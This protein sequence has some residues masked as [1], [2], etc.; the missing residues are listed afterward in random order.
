MMRNRPARYFGRQWSAERRAERAKPQPLRVA[1]TAPTVEF[2][3]PDI[4]VHVKNRSKNSPHR[5]R[6]WREGRRNCCYCNVRL[7]MKL[8]Q[9]NTLTVDHLTPTG[10]GGEHHPRN[11]GAACYDCNHEKGEMTE[12]EF[13][14]LRKLRHA[15]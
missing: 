7:T 9:R 14:L 4:P 11:M 8:N 10:R 5:H 13:R 1:A 6:M 2:V 3:A 15:A 12:E